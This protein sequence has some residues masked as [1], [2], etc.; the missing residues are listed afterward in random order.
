[1]KW[2]DIVEGVIGQDIDYLPAAVSTILFCLLAMTLCVIM[3]K[4]SSIILP[5]SIKLYALDY[6][7][8]IAFCTYPIAYGLSR[9]HHGHIGYFLVMVPINVVSLLLLHEGC[10][11]PIDNF[12][13]Y[14]RGT[15]SLWKSVIRT[16][17]Q[18]IGAY[19]AFYL[20]QQ[21]MKLEFH[22]DFAEIISRACTS[23]LKISVTAGFLLEL[24]GT[25]W[26]TWFW[27]QKLSKYPHLDMV[28]LSSNTALVVSLGVH[29]TGMYL[30]PALATG[31]T[32]G[33][34]GIT[35]VEHFFVYW[36]G[37]FIGGYIA[38]KFSEKFNFQLFY[39]GK[40]N[41]EEKQKKELK[42]KSTSKLRK[43]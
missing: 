29:L 4:L 38:Y 21:I 30:Q 32:L 9:R 6:F 3:H 27:L 15:Q 43:D 13:R 25:C 42:K 20:A 22:E 2:Q 40:E 35:V 31:Y 37:P 17:I 24:A 39:K 10:A 23:D 28:I 26:D 36:L 5:D 8:S 1:M 18:V 41:R 34:H 19:S 12:L 7:K 16:I 33:C 14:V 11:N